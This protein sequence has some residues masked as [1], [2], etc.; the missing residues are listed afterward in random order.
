MG[1]YIEVTL[2]TNSQQRS[3]IRQ[4]ESVPLSI[5]EHRPWSSSLKCFAKNA[6]TTTTTVKLIYLDGD[7]RLSL[8]FRNNLAEYWKQIKGPIKVKLEDEKRDLQ[9]NES[10]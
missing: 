6:A 10:C 1:S 8:Q 4:S 9:T 5:V 7:K 2:V 3:A